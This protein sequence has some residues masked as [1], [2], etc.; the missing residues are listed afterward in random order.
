MPKEVAEIIDGKDAKDIRIGYALEIYNSRGV[1]TIDPEGKPELALSE[2]WKKRA[3]VA[4]SEGY[5]RF[6]AKLRE[7]SESYVRE[8][9]RNIDEFSNRI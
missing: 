6:G 8:A 9:Q 5:P 4:A 1:H 3:E 2:K 7:V